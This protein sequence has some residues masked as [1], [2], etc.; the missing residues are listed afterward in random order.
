MASLSETLKAKSEE[1]SAKLEA[2]K[3]AKK[4][5]V[6]QHWNEAKA[7]AAKSKEALDEKATEGKSKF[8]AKL[9]GI[10]EK[11]QSKK[12]AIGEKVDATKA[13]AKSNVAEW[14]AEDAEAYAA[15]TLDVALS[16]IDEANA[17]AIEAI[18][19]RQKAE[20]VKA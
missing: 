15:A 9:N 12:E 6:E 17:A 8:Q 11:I 16:Y 3:T 4:E 2:A 7:K 1:F 5:Q 18:Y 19:A 14:S 13:H 10:K 20:A